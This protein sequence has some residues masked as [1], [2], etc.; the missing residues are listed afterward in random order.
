MNEKNNRRRRFFANKMHR[1]MFILVFC[2]AF[3]PA[4]ITAVSLFYLIFYITAEQL[5]FPEAIVYNLIPV[6][7]KVITILFI[8]TPL[9][10]LAIIILAHNLTHRM[11]G[12]FDR[13]IRELNESINGRRQGPIILRKNDKFQ[14][15]VEKINILL[16]KLKKD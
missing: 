4:L 13:I 10:I 7:Q 11:I 2:A 6:S 3:L 8:A 15:L 5:A 9:S 14:P 12:P 1:E 16:E